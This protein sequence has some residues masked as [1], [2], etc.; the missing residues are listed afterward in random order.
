MLNLPSTVSIFLYTQ[1][2]DM[3]SY[4]VTVVMRSRATEDAGGGDRA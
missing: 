2:A 1:P 3:R 4:A